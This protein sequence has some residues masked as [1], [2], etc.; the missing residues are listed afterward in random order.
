MDN[1]PATIQ[2]LYDAMTRRF[3]GVDG[4]L[5]AITTTVKAHDGQL[6]AIVRTLK[7]HDEQLDVIATAVLRHENHSLRNTPIVDDHEERIDH[8]E[9]SVSRLRLRSS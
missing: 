5:D 6:N 9:R 8:L 2:D 3:D 1:R 7:A 4:Q